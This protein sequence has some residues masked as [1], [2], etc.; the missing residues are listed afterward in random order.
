MK[1][2]LLVISLIFTAQ[3]GFAQNSSKHNEL[4]ER[5]MNAYHAF[6]VGQLSNNLTN[7]EDYDVKY[8][9][10]E[11]RLNPDTSIGK[12]VKEPLP[13]TSKH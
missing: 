11:L 13:C 9:R 6:K 3:L 7:G 12:Y 4:V 10:L 8:Y 2:L 1:N 5:E